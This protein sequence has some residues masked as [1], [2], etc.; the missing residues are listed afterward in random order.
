MQD[1]NTAGTSQEDD[2]RSGRPKILTMDEQVDA[3][4]DIVLD[5]KHFTVGRELNPLVLV[6]LMSTLF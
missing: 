6:L 1:S 3:I 4:H 2:P 5:D